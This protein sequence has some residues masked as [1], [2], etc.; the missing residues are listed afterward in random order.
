MCWRLAQGLRHGLISWTESCSKTSY[1]S[2]GL[3]K[4]ICKMANFLVFH[5]TLFIQA[6]QDGI[7]EGF[8]D[9]CV[10][11]TVEAALNSRIPQYAQSC[12]LI[13]EKE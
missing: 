13:A 3:C 7:F 1:I 9:V 11:N 6:A 10:G 5:I 12:L 2:T 8:W 4:A